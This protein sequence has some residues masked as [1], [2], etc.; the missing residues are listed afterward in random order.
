MDTAY[1]VVTVRAHPKTVLVAGVLFA[2]MG[3]TGFMDAFSSKLPTARYVI[4]FA[5]LLLSVAIFRIAFKRRAPTPGR[6]QN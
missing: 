4:S 2:F 6:D 3:I 1:T 5:C